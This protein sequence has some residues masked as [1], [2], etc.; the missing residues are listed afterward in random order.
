LDA[1]IALAKSMIA[2]GE[3]CGKTT[4]A[5]L[6]RM[7]HPLGN[8]VGNWIEVKECVDIMTDPERFMVAN[9]Q[10]LQLVLVQAAQM[11]VQSNVCPNLKDGISLARSKL[12][13]GS[14]LAKFREM[15]VAQGGDP[16]Y[17]DS[18][19][20]YPPASFSVRPKKL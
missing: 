12:R 9:N 15:V 6:T 19:N 11:L 16:T 4:T 20:D 18:P 2:A 13:D 5:F 14:A 10:V 1:A 17:I 8:A 3:A 7:D